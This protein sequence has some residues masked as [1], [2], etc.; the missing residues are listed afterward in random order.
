MFFV[1]AAHFI[2]QG[3]VDFLWCFF[4]VW[5]GSPSGRKRF[6]VLA[7]LNA[8]SHEVLTVSNDSYIESWA[9]IDL[10]WKLR[11]R[12]RLTGLPIS[13]VLDNA[14]YQR[15][16]IVRYLAKLMGIEL[17]YLPSYSPNLNLI[18]R[19]WKFVRKQ[20]LASKQY[21]TFADFCLAI[22]NCVECAHINYADELA[23]LLTWNFQTLSLVTKLAA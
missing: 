21:D 13:I 9:V 18:E 10:L 19:L 8:V 14:S 2:W 1:D 15:S 23:S 17:V 11:A 22:Q 6:N 4:K 5:F 3:Y 12:H 20:S 16:E 7:A